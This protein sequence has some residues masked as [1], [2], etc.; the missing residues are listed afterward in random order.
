MH[1]FLALKKS[2]YEDQVAF[3]LTRLLHGMTTPQT[4]FSTTKNAHGVLSEQDCSEFNVRI[5]DLV[6]KFRSSDILKTWRDA[7]LSRVSKAGPQQVHYEM[8]ASGLEFMQNTYMF[9]NEGA[10]G[11]RQHCLV[12]SG[13]PDVLLVPVMLAIIDKFNDVL[14]SP[15]GPTALHTI[16]LVLKAFVLMT[17][18]MFSYTRTLRAANFTVPFL[19]SPS[20]VASVHEP[21]AVFALLLLF[22]TNIDSM[23]PPSVEDTEAEQAKIDGIATALDTVWRKYSAAKKEQVV[24]LFTTVGSLPVSRQ[25]HTYGVFLDMLGYQGAGV[26][27]EEGSKENEQSSDNETTKQEGG[28]GRKTSKSYRLLG[29]LP[30]FARQTV[31]STRWQVRNPKKEKK[32]KKNMKEREEDAATGASQTHEGGK[33]AT[34]SL[35]EGVAK[36]PTASAVVLGIPDEF[37]CSLN[38]NVMKEPMRSKQTGLC[39]EKKSLEAWFEKKGHVC[40]ATGQPLAPK[41]VVYDQAL[42]LQITNFHIQQS[43]QMNAGAFDTEEDLYSF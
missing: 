24:Q 16:K 17:F 13:I 19:S 26:V 31:A 10:T 30:N 37:V 9:A 5:S 2:A 22:N 1:F 25:T 42:A 7:V 40:P 21:P 33:E 28:E 35:D 29:T 41:D 43:C 20:L 23:S 14:S 8:L 4:Y 15:V 18:E 12:A 27:A 11:F 32:R 34:T 3:G 6:D 38:G 36:Y 39:F